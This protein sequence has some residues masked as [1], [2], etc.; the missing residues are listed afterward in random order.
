MAVTTLCRPYN[1]K[2]SHILGLTKKL[3]LEV[4]L[5]HLHCRPSLGMGWTLIERERPAKQ[6]KSEPT[7][8]WRTA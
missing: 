5:P 3:D 4:G 7:V 2:L 6:P 8:S 1:G